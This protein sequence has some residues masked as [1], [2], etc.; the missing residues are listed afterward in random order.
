MSI[1]KVVEILLSEG[2]DNDVVEV[3][4][5]NRVTLSVLIDLDEVDFKELGITAFGD[6]RR[7][8]L[9]IK[10]LKLSGISQETEEQVRYII[11]IVHYDTN[12]K[13]YTSLLSFMMY[14][15]D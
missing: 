14:S 9:L 7:L 6:R 2:F 10:K 5:C 11:I 1:G 8:K 3:L 12:F 13:C 4:R 15:V